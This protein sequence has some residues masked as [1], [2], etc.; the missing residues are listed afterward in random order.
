MEYEMSPS[1]FTEL[2]YKYMYMKI[3]PTRYAGV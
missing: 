1:L 2:L 3:V